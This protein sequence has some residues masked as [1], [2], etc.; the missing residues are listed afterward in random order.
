M[1]GNQDPS[2]NLLLFVDDDTCT[3][4]PVCVYSEFKGELRQAD[5][6]H[7]PDQVPASGLFDAHGL[8]KTL[9]C[10]YAHGKRELSSV[11]YFSRS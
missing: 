4:L 3:S 1:P 5:P 11:N 8:P 9:R 2:N 10:A 6:V 7:E